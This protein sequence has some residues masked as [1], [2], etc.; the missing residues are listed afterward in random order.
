MTSDAECRLFKNNLFILDDL[1]DYFKK[2]EEA[3]VYSL[4]IRTA[5]RPLHDLQNG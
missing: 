5:G 3:D 2:K 4:L 1:K